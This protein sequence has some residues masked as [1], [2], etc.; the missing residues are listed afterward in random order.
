[1]KYG[2]TITTYGPL[3]NGEGLKEIYIYIV[4]KI[5]FKMKC[6]HS[7]TFKTYLYEDV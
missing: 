2:E 1:M 3:N 7:S 4:I 6:M 5:V